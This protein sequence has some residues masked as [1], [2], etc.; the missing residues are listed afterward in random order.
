VELKTGISRFSALDKEGQ[1]LSLARFGHNLTIAARDTFV[2][3]ADGVLAPERLRMISECQHRIFGHMYD[4]MTPSEWRR[5]DETIVSIILD[6]SDQH[7]RSQAAWAFEEALDH[8]LSSNTSLE[9]TR[10]E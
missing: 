10:E 5:P 2:P 7:L 4:L 1:L 8:V 3:Q 9:R 6:H